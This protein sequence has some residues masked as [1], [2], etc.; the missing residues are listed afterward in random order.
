[1]RRRDTVRMSYITIE[2]SSLSHFLKNDTRIAVLWLVVRV[3]LGWE[4][5]QAGWGKFNNPAWIGDN[6]GQGIG[7]FVQNALKK[8]A[9]ACAPAPAVCHADVQ[10]WYAAFLQ[11]FV[12]PYPELWSYLITFGEIAVGIGLIVG[13]L[14]GLAAFFGFTMN[15][16]FMLA[17]TVSTNPIMMVLA[18]LLVCSWRVAG[19]WGLDQYVLPVVF[20]KRYLKR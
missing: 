11:T 15:L 3:Y 19:Y 20:R 16:N 17:G 13:C 18:I 1:M 7:G 9:D 8:T 5:L 4:W 2:E 14:T 10:S 6:I 12:Q